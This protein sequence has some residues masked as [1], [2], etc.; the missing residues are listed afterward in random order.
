MFTNPET[1]WQGKL[2]FCLGSGP[3]L[4]KISREEWKEIKKLQEEKA[5]V[6]FAA[7]SAFKLPREYDIECDALFFTDEGWFQDNEKLVKE[8]QG[9]KLTVSRRA[10]NLYPELMRIENRHQPEF[11]VGCP[12]MK[13][14]RSSGHRI[15]SLG[16]M[17]GGKVIGLLG[18]DMRFVEIN[19]R[20]RS[21]FHDEY[22]D[23]E[24]E[25]SYSQEFVRSFDGW[26]EAALNVGSEVI[27]LTPDSAVEEF[28]NMNLGKFLGLKDGK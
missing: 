15:V 2:V 9:L 4:A 27:N 18:Y 10:K 17:M 28:P 25:K 21:H 5:C 6:I 8:F 19:G 22:K 16:I 26:H 20:K 13:D 14:G 11:K 7:N 12:P 23:T 24:S 1:P 3:S